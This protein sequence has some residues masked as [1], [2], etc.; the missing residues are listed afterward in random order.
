MSFLYAMATVAGLKAWID[1]RDRCEASIDLASL[2][3]KLEKLSG[4]IGSLT[5]ATLEPHERFIAERL[6]N[7]V[8]EAIGLIEGQMANGFSVYLIRGVANLN[9]SEVYQAARLGNEERVFFNIPL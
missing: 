9:M 4:V 3:E 2:L 1:G 6:G 5:P 8:A 7:S